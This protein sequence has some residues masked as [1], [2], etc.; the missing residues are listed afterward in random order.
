MKASP[1]ESTQAGKT[2]GGILLLCGSDS[3]PLFPFGSSY[4]GHRRKSGIGAGSL[5]AI[6]APG[7]S[8]PAHVPQRR[9]GADLS[10]LEGITCCFHRLDVTVPADLASL[11][12]FIEA[13]VGRVDVLIN[14]AG[15]YLDKGKSILE[16]GLDEFRKSVETNTFAP[17][18]LGRALIPIMI[19]NGYGRI[20]NV[21]SAAGLK[22][23]LRNEGPAYRISKAA[24][25]AV[26]LLLCQAV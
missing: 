7:V 18:A 5:P 22:R 14:N 25:N 20:V 13:E 6:G 8:D 17:L 4:L 1:P 16:V 10:G 2:S 23:N 9:A 24:L 12:E 26:T 3:P 15:I 19:R 21:S 11:V